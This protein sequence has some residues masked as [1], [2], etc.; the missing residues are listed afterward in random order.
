MAKLISLG[1]AVTRGEKKTLEYLQKK[2]PVDWVIFGN[3][4]VTTGELTREIDA[5]IVG[6][7]CV[8]AVDE[9]GFTGP[10]TG[11]EHTWI[12]E[13]GTARE[14][15]LN[16]ILH[17][18]KMLKGKLA[19]MDSRL[20]AIWVEGV[21]ILSAPDVQLRVNDSRIS[22]HVCQ[23]A[24]VDSFFGQVSCQGKKLSPH[25]RELIEG[26]IAGEKVV[27]RI[28]QRLQRIS[29][30]RLLEKLAAGP[31]VQSYRAE[32]EKFGEEVLL[33]L[34]DFSYLP[35]P[36]SREEWQKR[37][38]RE[39]R[40]LSKLRNIPGVVRVVESFQEVSGYGGDLYFF[41]LDLPSGPSLASR[42]AEVEWSAEN[43]LAAAKRLC[44][45]V[46]SFHDAKVIHRQLT[47]AN[48]Y[49]YQTD[50]DFVVTGF[51]LSKLPTSSLHP[52]DDL[53]QS[54]YQ[55]PEVTES[56]H[57]AS[58]A[59]DVY[60]LGVILFEIFSGAKPFGNRPRQPQD[61]EPELHFWGDLSDL[62]KLDDLQAL[63][64]LMVAYDSK[65]RLKNLSE[66]LDLLEELLQH[67]PISLPRPK[68][69]L[70]P[71]PQGA[72]IGDYIILGYL[73]TG[74]CF[75]AYRVAR[76][77]EDSQEYV[78][79]VLRYPELLESA[80]WAF[81]ALSVLDHPNIIRAFDVRT[82]PESSYH[83]LEKYVPGKSCR[84]II[85][86]GRT[87]A[88]Q[89]AK[90]AMA[91][92]N[93]LA[94]METRNPA[95]YHGDISPT[96]III[97]KD[98]P[99]LIDFGL[100]YLGGTGPLGGIVGTAPY[101]PPERD[102]PNVDWP[103]SGDVYSLGLVLCA[104]LFGELPYDCEGGVWN[105]QKIREDFFSST[106]LA[107]RELLEVLR[108]AIAPEAMDRFANA[109]EFRQALVACPE[110]GDK[111]PLIQQ[112]RGIVPYL[113]EAIKV[114]NL[115]ACNAENRGLD[116]PF[117]RATYVPTDL[118]RELMPKIL[119][120]RFALV[121]LAGNPGDGKTAFLQ[122]LALRLGFEGEFLPLNHWILEHGGW[123][124]ECV[125][126]G[127]AA[128]SL[129][130]LS[131]EEVLERLFDPLVN[132]GEIPDLA[133]TL[134][135]TQLL[136]I[137]DGRLLEFLND[138]QQKSNW[139]LDHLARFFDPEL[140]QPH[141]EIVLVDLN[142]R[143]LV[144][145]D[146][147]QSA[148]D[149]ILTALLMGGWGEFK[150]AD[151]PWQICQSC[152]AAPSCHVRFHVET[153]RNP[154]LG[155]QV[156]ERLK[157]LL[158]I[159]HSQGR[160]HITIRELRSMLAYIIFGEQPCEEIHQELEEAPQKED[161]GE[162]RFEEFM[163]RQ[164]RKLYFERVFTTGERG[165]RLLA[166]L[167]DF[168]PGKVDNPRLDRFIASSLK[169]P[170]RLEDLFT[171]AADRMPHRALKWITEIPSDQNPFSG[172]A[173]VRR[174][175]FFEGKSPE[176]ERHA[177]AYSWLEMTP[178]RSFPKWVEN[179]TAFRQGRYELPDDLCRLVCRGI[180][181]TDNVPED[182]LD[183][184][185]AVRTAASPKTE[186]IVVRLFELEKFRLTWESSETQA[187][188][189]SALP[190][191]MLLQYGPEADPTLEISAELFELLIR[192]A[193]GYRL[194]SAELEGVAANLELF[195]NRLLAM[196]AKEVCLL[197]PSLGS[198]RAR[199]EL[200]EGTRRIILEAMS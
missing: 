175:L 186:L 150:P 70:H 16:N 166:E 98:Q 96:N 171:G 114:Y 44:E 51:E 34:Y 94:Y 153:L 46:K 197:H 129:R 81:N 174:R 84:D 110:L 61:P 72:Q 40:T 11:D 23:L 165:G 14:R 36:H 3:V 71:L 134:G 20:S 75:H 138:R 1:E 185:L 33:K 92:A 183:R 154:V 125:L 53:P 30:Y 143:S 5:I 155:A 74:G 147:L 107:S 179:L 73:G 10:I 48:I 172:F 133:A 26:L 45:I 135:R 182:L 177:R 89:V 116:S 41:A 105:K 35:E 169:S 188:I 198:Y 60:S 64:Q 13:N 115:G 193:E 144:A 170:E 109:Q 113:T 103:P 25:E 88:P 8:W 21:V 91:L 17:A 156:R 97:D 117:A 187:L 76:H 22:A 49:F 62:V 191:A 77:E 47:P 80:R 162:S 66:A 7:R 19:T 39:C 99:Y 120:H 163:K 63:I 12:F 200:Q 2:L 102:L 161:A 50:Y 28:K 79:K 118:D 68:P 126:D 180:S 137:N 82:A 196:P 140:G 122:Q 168:D 104:L 43:R 181:L 123:T 18:A 130:G 56:L 142:R 158:A 189:L 87:S 57:N 59:S 52:L 173:E 139:L 151:D 15:V 131:S 9:K 124:Y 31:V 85:A 146:N 112:E 159:V 157:T 37:A 86:Q 90:W 194:G 184:Y 145:G 148:F 69:S 95:V 152:R 54:P 119:N 24:D 93:A 58:E 127:S 160:L 106:N 111:A 121:I 27:A 178:F 149:E 192:F 101:R 195:K 55:A 164:K 67:K 128:D 141:P 42:L 167:V 176:E 65:E 6:D 136:A 199:Q 83:L 78:A 190:T 100:A 132:A 32:R 4:Q 38:E 29:H 108:R